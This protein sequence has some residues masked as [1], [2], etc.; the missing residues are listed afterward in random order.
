MAEGGVWSRVLKDSWAGHQVGLTTNAMEERDVNLFIVT[1]ICAD[2]RWT[3]AMKSSR[4]MLLVFPRCSI[5]SQVV[6][7]RLYR[8][9][10]NRIENLVELAPESMLLMIRELHIGLDVGVFPV[11]ETLYL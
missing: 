11:D 3:T 6:R 5:S 8:H 1:T 4:K 9:S 7:S 2:I 10:I